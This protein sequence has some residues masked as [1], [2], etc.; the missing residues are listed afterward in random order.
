MIDSSSPAA[1]RS[2]GE[3]Q[4]QRGRLLWHFEPY[5]IRKGAMDMF[6][7]EHASQTGLRSLP[8]PTAHARRAF[9]LIELLVVISIIALL[10]SILLPALGA[11]RAAARRTQCLSNQRQIGIAAEVYMDMYDGYMPAAGDNYNGDWTPAWDKILAVE[12][13]DKDLTLTPPGTNGWWAG[14]RTNARVLLCP[15]DENE[16]VSP[17]GAV[18]PAYGSYGLHDA[19]GNYGNDTPR[20]HDEFV[21]DFGAGQASELAWMFEMNEGAKSTINW[22]HGYT[23]NT[24]EH[25]HPEMGQ[26][27][28]LLF[29][30]M[31][32]EAQTANPQGTV[33]GD[34]YGRARAAWTYDF[35][36][37]RR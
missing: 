24:W 14:G 32:A 9:T 28:N 36:F 18:E 23:T 20:F 10:I 2:S 30:D 12:A 19:I 34:A 35:A 4:V 8:R 17:W 3:G 37:R 21:A 31:H 11:A 6:L 16:D 5:S 22:N 33:A 15:A 1:T 7:P 27:S 13:M 25:R 29:A 26:G